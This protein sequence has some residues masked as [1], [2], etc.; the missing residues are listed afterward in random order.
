MPFLNG[1]E[2]AP[3]DVKSTGQLSYARTSTPTTDA[4]YSLRS[5]LASANS[6]KEMEITIADLAA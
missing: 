4:R 5:P 6:R 2:Y 1:Y 3:A